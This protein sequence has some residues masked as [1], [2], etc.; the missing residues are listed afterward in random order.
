M[1]DTR[2]IGV[3][4]SGLGGLTVVRELFRLMPGER[5]VYL[6]DTAR[7]PYGG[8]SEETIRT[9]G[10]QDASC[11]RRWMSSSWSLPAI[12]YRRW[13]SIRIRRAIREIPVVGVVLPGARAACA[14]DRPKKRSGSS[15]PRQPS[16]PAHIPAQSRRSIRR[17]GFT[18]R[19]AR[20]SSP[21]R[22]G[23]A[24][25]RNHPAGG[26]VLYGRNPRLRRRLHHPRVYPLS[27]AHADHPG[28]GGNQDPSARQRALDRQRGTGYFK[29]HGRP[30][31]GPAGGLEAS[32]FM[33]TDCAPSFKESAAA[34]LGTAVPAIE[35]ISLE[36]LTKYVH[37]AGPMKHQWTRASISVGVL[38]H[39][40]DFPLQGAIRP[41]NR[42]GKGALNG[43]ERSGTN[44]CKRGHYVGS[45]Q[46]GN[47]QTVEGKNRRI[48]RQAVQPF[49]T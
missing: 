26:A 24:G 29:K 23:T 45:F 38:Y 18:A 25:S 17:S 20:C 36:K 10:L 44:H 2:P 40:P 4:D 41:A 34:F 33:V 12:P 6:G 47:N 30:L 42:T 21:G 28:D 37:G 5:V 7:C 48:A 9:F 16:G 49:D 31:D 3:F 46:M 8:R 43:R 14:A 11:C 32:R 1:S 13:R 22:R 15:A 27:A 35:C 39:P 19:H